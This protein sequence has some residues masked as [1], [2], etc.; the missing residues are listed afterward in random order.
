[1]GLSLKKIESEDQKKKTREPERVME[2]GRENKKKTHR[3]KREKERRA[4]TEM[5]LDQPDTP[6]P[7]ALFLSTTHQASI[8]PY[9][10]TVASMQE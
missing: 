8:L 6:L 10:A 1:L 9:P 7:S 3:R 5:P 2:R 4:I